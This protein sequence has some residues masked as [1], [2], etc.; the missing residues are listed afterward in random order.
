MLGV[1]LAEDD[2]V[3]QLGGRLRLVALEEHLTLLEAALGDRSLLL[4]LNALVQMLDEGPRRAGLFKENWHLV[5]TAAYE[6]GVVYE[7]ATEEGVSIEKKH[8]LVGLAALFANIS[9]VD[10]TIVGSIGEG[11]GICGE[12]NEIN[13]ANDR[14]GEESLAVRGD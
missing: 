1:H 9:K 3:L 7:G 5:E 13:P 6:G 14:E 4:V 8:G 11:R 2:V 10:L 12:G